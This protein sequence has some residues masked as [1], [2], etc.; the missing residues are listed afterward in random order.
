[1][2]VLCDNEG[3]IICPVGGVGVYNPGYWGMV[4]TYVSFDLL[5][6]DLFCFYW[7]RIEHLS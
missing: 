2:E 1:M 6:K 5:Q 4:C 3:S 7:N